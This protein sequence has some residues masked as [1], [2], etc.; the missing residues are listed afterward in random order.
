MSASVQHPFLER[1]R[2]EYLEMP[3]LCLKQNQVERLC[4]IDH[5]IC[6]TVLDALVAARFLCVKADGAYGRVTEGVYPRPRAAKAEL[7]PTSRLTKE[8]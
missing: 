3:G 8:S 1:I 6:R 5:A 2:T 7:R 4:G